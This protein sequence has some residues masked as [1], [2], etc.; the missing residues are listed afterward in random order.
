MLEG[1]T[2]EAWITV[3]VVAAMIAALIK[4]VGRPDIILL[5]SVGALLVTGVLSPEDAF[6]GFS[7]SAVLA[8]G[9]LFVVAAGVQ[10]A[11]ALSFADRFLFARSTNLPLATSRLMITTATMSAFLNNTPVVAMLIPRVQAWSEKTGVPTSKLMIPLSFGAIV[12]GMTTLIGTSTNLLVSGLMESSGYGSLG[13]FDLAWIGIPAAFGTVLFFALIGHRLLPDRNLEKAHMRDGVKDCLF[14]MQIAP[15]SPLV[16]LTV[17]EANLRALEDAYLVHL[18]RGDEVIPSSPGTAFRG[19]DVLTFLGH[20]SMHDRLLERPGLE[21]AQES[22]DNPDGAS[23]T[24]YE[25]VISPSSHLVGRSLRDVGFRERYQG[26]VLGIR[27]RD[28]AI[29]GP[30]GRIPL[31]AGDLLIVE[32]PSGFDARWSRQRDDFYLVASRQQVTATPERW[33][34]FLTLAILIAIVLLAAFKIA[35]IV[36]TAFAGALAMIGTGCLRGSE[37][38]AAVDIPVLLVIA[39]ALGLGQA[40]ETSGLAP[41]VAHSI[42]EHAAA[43]GVVGVVI[44]IYLATNLLTELITNNAAAALMLGIGLVAAQDLGLPPKVFAVTV[45]IAASASFLTPIGYQTNLMVLAAGGYKFGDFMKTGLC[46]NLIVGTIAVTMIWL[47]W[48]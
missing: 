46:V 42:T 22:V 20:S 41:F 37:A 7:N 18:H 21:R 47:V 27:R 45:A 1:L 26:V 30:L 4:N 25:A 32:A 10:K 35:P 40:I 38:R 19:N 29:E 12:G 28:T 34:T 17:E 43:Y 14:E 15:N 44:A 13:I 6:A 8:V 16:G 23:L 39:S 31:Q 5:G 3:A 11:G 33:K 36:T 24:I 9:S 48:L 2:W